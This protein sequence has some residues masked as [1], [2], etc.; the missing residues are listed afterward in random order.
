[1]LNWMM[2]CCALHLHTSHKGSKGC[3][4]RSG[5][6]L[7]GLAL[8]HRTSID[9]STYYTNAPMNVRSIIHTVYIDM[10]QTENGSKIHSCLTWCASYDVLYKSSHTHCWPEGWRRELGLQW[11]HQWW[12]PPAQPA[13]YWPSSTRSSHG[14]AHLGRHGSRPDWQAPSHMLW[15]WWAPAGLWRS[16]SREDCEL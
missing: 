1:M 14:S 3:S 9:T 15:Q 13:I 7:L 2:V 6:W 10:A 11:T 4:H 16:V 5:S 8:P 12:S